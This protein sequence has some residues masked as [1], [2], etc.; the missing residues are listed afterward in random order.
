MRSRL[1]SSEV[2]WPSGKLPTSHSPSSTTDCRH[3]RVNIIWVKS[4]SLS[5][6]HNTTVAPANVNKQRPRVPH[7]P[8]VANIDHD[9]L[10]MQIR[11]NHT[12][13]VQS[14]YGGVQAL[15]KHPC[16]LERRAAHNFVVVATA[17]PIVQC[18]RSHPVRSDCGGSPTDADGNEA[19]HTNAILNG[20]PSRQ[21]GW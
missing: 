1:A 18:R 21:L 15:D 6:T 14:L 11:V 3:H 2:A 7:A 12:A 19:R 13:L 10:G 9:A 5:R 16:P 4:V 17:V 20:T 8:P